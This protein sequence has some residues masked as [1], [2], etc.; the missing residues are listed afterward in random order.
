ME[1]NLKCAECGGETENDIRACKGACSQ[2]IYYGGDLMDT[3]GLSVCNCC[4]ECR[5]R[6]HDSFMQS[7]EDGEQ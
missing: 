5:W 7:I 3:K 6:C 2:E 4:E 1:E